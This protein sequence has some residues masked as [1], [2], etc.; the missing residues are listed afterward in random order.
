M[1]LW[2]HSVFLN[3]EAEGEDRRERV[4]ELQDAQRS[5]ETRDC[6]ELR[7]GGADYP[8]NGPVCRHKS[9]PE[10][11][12]ACTGE[13]WCM[14]EFLEDFDICDLDTDIAVQSGCNKAGYDCQAESVVAQK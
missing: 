5:D 14:Q 8:G 9:D 4:G 3:L 2:Q 10:N 1:L 7:D 6:R 11:L 13:R 12:S